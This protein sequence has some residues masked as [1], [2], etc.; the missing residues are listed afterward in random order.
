LTDLPTNIYV[1]NYRRN[2]I[3]VLH[4]GGSMK[5]TNTSHPLPL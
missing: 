3:S 5:H 1:G 2:M 4:L